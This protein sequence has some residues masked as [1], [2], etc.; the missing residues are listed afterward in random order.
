MQK[1]REAMD[2]YFSFMQNSLSAYPW[3]NNEV[4]E[5]LKSVAEK[6]V[7]AFHDYVRNMG[8]AGDLEAVIQIQTEFIKSQMISFADQVKEI[9]ETC[10]KAA[11]DASKKSGPTS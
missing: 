7:A 6:N 3:G 9:G 11:V 5:K 4:G 10:Y 1:T 2:T 8:Q